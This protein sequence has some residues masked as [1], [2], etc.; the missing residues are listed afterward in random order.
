M[1]ELILEAGGTTA[2]IFHVL[3]MLLIYLLFTI[4]F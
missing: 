3:F 1:A 2:A 4:L